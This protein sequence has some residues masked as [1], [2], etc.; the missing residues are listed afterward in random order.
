MGLKALP[1]GFDNFKRVISDG[2]YYVDKTDLIKDLIDKGAA[3]NL[4]TRPRR[5][6]KSLNMS[7]LQYFLRIR[8][9]KFLM[10]KTEIYSMVSESW[11]PVISTRI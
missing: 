9:T 3:V 10:R 11:K 5:F 6:G 8:E 2:F 1:I 7:M 4:F